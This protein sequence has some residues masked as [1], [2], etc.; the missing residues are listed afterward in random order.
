M[1]VASQRR[2]P[3]GSS[4]GQRDVHDPG[5]HLMCAPLKN[6]GR[7]QLITGHSGGSA[8]GSSLKAPPPA[9]CVI[10]RSKYADEQQ[11]KRL[12]QVASCALGVSD[13]EDVG[14]RS[15]RRCVA[16]SRATASTKAGEMRDEEEEEE[17]EEAK[18]WFLL[19]LAGLLPLGFFRVGVSG[20]QMAW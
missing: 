6:S 5:I 19:L 7:W 9:G 12:Q 2:V 14:R 11:T 15:W 3:L 4:N 18:N 20:K 8:D 1:A 16:E 13:E 10:R 17:E